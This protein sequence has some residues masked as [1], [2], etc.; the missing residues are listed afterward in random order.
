MSVVDAATPSATVKS[1]AGLKLLR[2]AVLSRKLGI[3]WGYQ[4]KAESFHA[5]VEWGGM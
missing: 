5:T 3:V 2:V 1:L 4:H